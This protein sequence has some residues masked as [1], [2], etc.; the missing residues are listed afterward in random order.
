M[1]LI[2]IRKIIF[3]DW[4]FL[5]NY[6]I[7]ITFTIFFIININ[8]FIWMFIKYGYL[9]DIRLSIKK[10]TWYEKTVYV[11]NILKKELNAA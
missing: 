8:F 7:F 10:N 2:P 1:Q 5:T 9:M 11:M 6:N 4:K 3:A